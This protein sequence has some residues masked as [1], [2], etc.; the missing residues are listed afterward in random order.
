[1][2]YYKIKALLIS[3]LYYI[4][5]VHNHNEIIPN[6]YIGNIYSSLFNN[7]EFDVIVNCSKNLPFPNNEVNNVKIRIPIDDKYFNKCDELIN[8]LE[9]I[10]SIVKH[11]DDKKKILIHCQFGIQRSSTIATIFLM[12]KFNFQKEKAIEIVKSHRMISFFPYNNFTHI[13]DKLCNNL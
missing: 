11:Y 2:I 4:L 6:I 10:N 12:K 7:E 3:S 9:I 8:H 13:F 1:M 5:G